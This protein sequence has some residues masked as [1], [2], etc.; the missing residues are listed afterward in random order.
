MIP[1]EG[2]SERE[3]LSLACALERRS[4]H[5]LAKAVMVR[6]ESEAVEPQEVSD[7]QAL[8]GNGLSAR[9]DGALLCGGNLKFIGSQAEV[10][11]PL[12]AQ[13]ELS[14]I[15]IWCQLATTTRSRS[16]AA[17]CCRARCQ[18]P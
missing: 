11:G 9:L 18:A 5:P 4:E 10:A 17:S 2:I 8:P 6:A 12:K 14:L 7:F 1:A 16:A 13:A 3:L 15:H